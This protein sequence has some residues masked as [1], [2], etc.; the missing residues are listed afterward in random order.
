MLAQ[1]QLVVILARKEFFVRYRR[2]SFG[3][4]WAVLLPLVQAGVLALVL[5]RF[6]RF[7]TDVAYAVFVYTGMLAWSFVSN[8]VT[9]SSTAI[10]DN[11]SITSRIYFPRAVLP[12]M[13]VMSGTY[14]FVGALPVL[15]VLPVLT[16][17]GLGPEIVLLAPAVL[18][19][20]ALAAAAGLVLSVLHV[21]FRDVR[22]IVSATL[23]PL[24]YATPVFYPLEALEGPLRTAIAANPVTGVVQVFRV[25]I[26]ED[27]VA[28]APVA[29]S[30]AAVVGLGAVGLV[31]QARRDRVMADLL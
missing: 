13:A 3:L 30:V 21:W 4:A 25:A 22:F 15:L 20:V 7:D 26:G 1:R 24:F 17:S 5:S 28:L 11:A 9:A 23:M 31:L 19:A 18:L 29:V 16:G 14:G 27:G 2:A 12:L 6:V 8:A 10:V